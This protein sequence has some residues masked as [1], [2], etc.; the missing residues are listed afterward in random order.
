MKKFFVLILAV[1]TAFCVISCGIL[2]DKEESAQPSAVEGGTEIK[3]PQP[4]E[5]ADTAKE[6]DEQESD[7][8]ANVVIDEDSDLKEIISGIS[9]KEKAG[10]MVMAAFRTDENEENIT[11]L[12]AGIKDA[13]NEYNLCGI[14]VFGENIKSEEQLRTFVS[15]AKSA[16]KTPIFVGIDEEGGKVSRIAKIGILE[17][18]NPPSAQTM[19]ENNSVYDDYSEIAQVLSGFGINLDFAPVADIN[20]NPDNI[21]IGDRAFGSDAQEAAQFVGQAVCALKEVGVASVLKHFPGHG[22]TKE[23]SH[24]GAATASYDYETFISREAVTF[25]NGIENGADMV[26]VAHILTPNL[27]ENDIPASMNPDIVTGILREDMGFDGVVI[28]DALDMGAISEYYSDGEA[29]VA[30]IKVGCDILLMPKSVEKT[31]NAIINAVENGEISQE[32]I[33]ESLLRI[34]KVKKEMGILQ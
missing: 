11:E 10:Q 17:D 32:R 14:V 30:A 19:A 22:D 16:A 20:T 3:Q 9:L 29:A 24:E 25:E 34:L 31:V 5:T 28:T 7:I 1:L 18:Y 8:S 21:V 4:S 13:I 27:S 2:S 12:S 15:D 6:N 33:D 26:M 23:D